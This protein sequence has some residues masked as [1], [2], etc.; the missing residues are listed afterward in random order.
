[1]VGIGMPVHNLGTIRPLEGMAQTE[2]APFRAMFPDQ[3]TK[4]GP[5]RTWRGP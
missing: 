4:K 1:M 2:T 3:G 5:R